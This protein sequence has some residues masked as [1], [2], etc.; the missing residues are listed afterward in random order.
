MD[1]PKIGDKV[2]FC[3][4]LSDMDKDDREEYPGI[5][6]KMIE[7]QLQDPDK[8]YTVNETRNYEDV[9]C[10][11]LKEDPDEWAY[12][13]KWFKYSVPVPREEQLLWKIKQLW[14]KQLYFK[15]YLT[16]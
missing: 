2:V 4:D 12:S 14:E 10:V 1:K 3:V 5:N 6:D 8:E 11:L 9:C 16:S 15:E 7:F 13:W